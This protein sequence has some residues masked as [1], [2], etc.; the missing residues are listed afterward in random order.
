MVEPTQNPQYEVFLDPS[1]FDM[2]CVRSAD[3][4]RFNSPMSFHF[5]LEKDA[6][7]FKE[8]IEKAK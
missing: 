5:N 6:R 1:Y 7:T 3:D 4:R 2:W 8:L